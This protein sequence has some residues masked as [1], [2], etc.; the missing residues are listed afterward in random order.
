MFPADGGETY[1]WVGGALVH[2]FGHTFGLKHPGSGHVGI[3]DVADVFGGET[4][5]QYADEALIRQI[6]DGHTRNQGW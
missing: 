3:M 4:G 2:E 5:I 6:Y 1:I